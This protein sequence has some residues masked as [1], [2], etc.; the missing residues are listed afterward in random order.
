MCFKEPVSRKGYG[1]SDY[2]RVVG[3]GYRRIELLEDSELLENSEDSED[4]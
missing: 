3:R 4:L 1:F 2:G